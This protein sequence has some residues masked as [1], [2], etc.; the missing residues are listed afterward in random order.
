MPLH[1]STKYRVIKYVEVHRYGRYTESSFDVTRYVIQRKLLLFYF[2]FNITA[3]KRKDGE[4]DY[5]GNQKDYNSFEIL[6]NA[7]EFIKR[8]K[9]MEEQ[10][11]Q[12]KKNKKKNEVIYKD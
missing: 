7:I 6:E 9:K 5:F 3:C 4:L 10:E 11:Y 2:E 12:D 8:Y 1:R